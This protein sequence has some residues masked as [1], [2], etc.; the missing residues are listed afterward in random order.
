MEG[1]TLQ[2]KTTQN[3]TNTARPKKW[4]KGERE[5][6]REKY[7]WKC[8]GRIEELDRHNT[9]TKNRPISSMQILR[10]ANKVGAGSTYSS[11]ISRRNSTN[12]YIIHKTEIGRYTY[13]YTKKSSFRH[14]QDLF[15]LKTI[16]CRFQTRINL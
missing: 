10:L 1:I 14:S 7:H 4:L 15:C 16:F 11:K 5:R 6:E 13:T 3:T 2:H 8:I 12:T 9:H